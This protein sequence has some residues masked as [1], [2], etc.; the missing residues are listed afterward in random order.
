MKR[1]DGSAQNDA[2]EYD[3]SLAIQL[4]NDLLDF[5]RHGDTAIFVF[6]NNNSLHYD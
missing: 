4:K 2:E 5:I 3:L 6:N 1:T